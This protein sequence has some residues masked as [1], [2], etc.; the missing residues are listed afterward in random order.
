LVD[1]LHAST[2]DLT[3]ALLTDIRDHFGDRLAGMY[4]YGSAVY[5]DFD[6]GVSDLD[7][8]A[9]LVADA[10]DADLTALRAI[11][12]RIALRF[13]EWEGRVEV[14]YVSR[15]A[16]RSFRT[17]RHS[18]IN[19][20]PGEPIH[21]IEA[22]I[23]W[24]VNWYFIRDHGLVLYGPPAAEVVPSISSDEFVTAARNHARDWLARLDDLDRSQSQSY[25]IL[26][27]CRAL[28]THRTGRQVSK[29]RAAEW[30]STQYPAWKPAVD[31]ALRWR[32]SPAFPSPETAERARIIVREIVAIIDRES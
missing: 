6:P 30:V 4:A 9:V 27:N 25:A 16:L 15:D 2:H 1:K 23:E 5:G 21:F 26:T 20:S 3:A 28:F 29:A 7:M 12:D 14:Q 32:I 22:G 8:T 17:R 19:I 31:D 13:P 18:M 11:H 24:L 10:T